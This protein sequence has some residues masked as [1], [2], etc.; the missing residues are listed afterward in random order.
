MERSS[1][2]STARI[3]NLRKC[4]EHTGREGEGWRW[5]RKGGGSIFTASL[6]FLLLLPRL[7]KGSYCRLIIVNNDFI[8]L[9]QLN[10]TWV[11]RINH[12]SLFY[13]KKVITK[14][15]QNKSNSRPRTERPVTPYGNNKS[16]ASDLGPGS[17]DLLR[18]GSRLQS[19]RLL[20]TTSH[21]CDNHM[22]MKEHRDSDGDHAVD[23][24][25]GRLMA[26]TIMMTT[27]SV[28]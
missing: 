11:Q 19:A 28:V 20:H 15:S 21:C 27:F 8:R 9:G 26:T 12:L 18:S 17:V 1:F 24:S 14:S 4:R 7:S 6:V 10:K 16:I 22:R 23:V 2:S 13:D 3:V 5:R 25:D